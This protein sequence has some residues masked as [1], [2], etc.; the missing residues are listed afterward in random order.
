[1]KKQY[2][3]PESDTQQ[4]L[5]GNVCQVGSV[6]GTGELDFGGEVNPE[7]GFEPG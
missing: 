3:S 6:R 5:F 2:I 1:M 4:L 7:S